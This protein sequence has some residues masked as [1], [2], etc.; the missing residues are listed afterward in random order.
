MRGIFQIVMV[1]A[2]EGNLP[3]IDENLRMRTAAHTVKAAR[4]S[5]KY[6]QTG[7]GVASGSHRCQGRPNR[8]KPGGRTTNYKEDNL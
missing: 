1:L 2:G 3:H 7:H 4:D 8:L 6:G 5:K